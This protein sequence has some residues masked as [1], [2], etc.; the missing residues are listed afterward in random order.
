MP[1]KSD[2]SKYIACTNK[3]LQSLKK[4]IGPQSSI[5]KIRNFQLQVDKA[6]EETEKKL[7][8]DWD[9]NLSLG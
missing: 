1:K 9:K 8:S 6:Y 5:Q 3:T 2:P 4:I 7:N